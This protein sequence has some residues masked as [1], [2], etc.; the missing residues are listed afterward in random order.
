MQFDNQESAVAAIK[1]MNQT[2]LLGETIGK[3][4]RVVN[5]LVGTGYIR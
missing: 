4:L 5:S 1:G 2:K 3:R